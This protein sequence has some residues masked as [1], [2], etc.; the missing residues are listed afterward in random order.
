MYVTV[1]A[2]RAEGVSEKQANDGRL[3]ALIEDATQMIDGWTGWFFAPRALRL[4]MSG[5]QTAT[6][7]APVPLIEAHAL[8]INGFRVQE[9][10]GQIL[11]PTAPVLAGQVPGDLTLLGGRIFSAGA[12]NVEVEGLWGYTE[13]DGSA[14]GRTPP[15]IQRVCKLLVLRSIPKLTDDDAVGEAIDRW[16]LIEARTRDQSYKLAPLTAGKLTGDPEIDNALLRY[17]RPMQL[18]AA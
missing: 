1:E 16:R 5:R 13:A 12:L 15:E 18:G 11:V 4:R 3:K 8:T 14:H 17:R 9:D 7:Q 6:L 2:L 10:L